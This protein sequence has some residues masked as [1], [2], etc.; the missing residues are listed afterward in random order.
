MA[1]RYE[2][3][4]TGVWDSVLGRVIQFREGQA[5]RDYQNWL[6][7]GHAPDPMPPVTPAAP[8]Q[9]ELDALAEI[10]ARDTIRM[11]LRNDA[12]IRAL[13]TRSPAQVNSWID[14]N[15]TDVASA[16]AVLKIIAQV[17]ALYIREHLPPS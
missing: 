14:S 1:A 15:V 8:T 17:M 13:A 16:R 4:I 5:W 12:A 3:R 11:T 10:N 9:E 7:T 6:A 2:L